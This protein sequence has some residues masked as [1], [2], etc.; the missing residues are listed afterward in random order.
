MSKEKG[1]MSPAN[2]TPEPTTGMA[3]KRRA[4]KVGVLASLFGLIGRATA[5]AQ[6]LLTIDP[7]GATI[8][9]KHI[10]FGTRFGALLTLWNPGYELGIQASTIYPR[11]GKN[12]A[13]YKGGKYVQ[14]ELDPGGG[15]KMM[16]LLRHADRQQQIRGQGRGAARCRLDVVGR[17][18][19]TAYGLGPVQW[20]QRHTQPAGPLRRR[21]QLE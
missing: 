11:S 14:T 20:R 18:G 16:C 17:P 5:R 8:Y 9:A 7:D 2:P 19:E 15:N 21:L 6:D 1:N 10:N 12:F 13:W 4:L 3:V